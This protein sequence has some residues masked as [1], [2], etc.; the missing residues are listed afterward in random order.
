MKTPAQ[1]PP[2]A[3]AP[4]TMRY[5]CTLKGEWG[6]HRRPPEPVLHG[7][8][9]APRLKGEWDHSSGGSSVCLL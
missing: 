4:W 5:P 1:T 6:S 2:R 3:C 7:P 8:G 9:R